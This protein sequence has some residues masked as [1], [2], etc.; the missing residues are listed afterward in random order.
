MAET[1]CGREMKDKDG[2]GERGL[3][4]LASVFPYTGMI[5]PKEHIQ[6]YTAFIKITH[7]L[8]KF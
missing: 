8:I 1:V 7:T 4:R 3:H 5:P 2:L 6:M